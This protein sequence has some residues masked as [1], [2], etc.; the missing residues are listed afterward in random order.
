MIIA[1]LN[2]GLACGVI[3]KNGLA[4][5][6]ETR[7]WERRRKRWARLGMIGAAGL[8]AAIYGIFVS[9]HF[10]SISPPPLL[11]RIGVFFLL[12]AL[13]GASLSD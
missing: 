10:G 6:A 2:L 9:G 12:A 3:L 8:I 5:R 1:Y 7:G 13:L 4:L 11:A